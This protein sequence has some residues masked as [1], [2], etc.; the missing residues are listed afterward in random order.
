M[1]APAPPGADGT[2]RFDSAAGRWVLLTTVLGSGMAFLDGTVVTVALPRIGDDLGADF[3]GLSWISNAYLVT[4][5]A[6][7]LVGGSTGDRLGHRRTYLAG[8]VAFAATS[9]LCALA[10][11]VGALVGARLLQGVAAAFLVPGSLALL[12]ASFHPDDRSR[13]IGAWSGLAGVTTAIGPFLGGWLVEVATWRWVFLLNLPLAA[14][15]VVIGRRHLPLDRP[16]RPE[17]PPDVL[18]AAVVTI[19]LAATT[20]GLVEESVPIAGLGVAALVGFV[21]VEARSAHPMLPLSMFRVPAFSGANVTTFAVYGALGA[22]LFL[23][24]LVLQVALGYS[25]L[26]AGAATVPITVVMLA[27]SSRS[28]ALA[29]RIG[30]RLPMTVGPSVI[31]IGLLLMLRIEPGTSYVATVLPALLVFSSGLTLTVAPLTATVLAAVTPDHAG[32]ASGV[33]NAVAR[34]AGLVAVASLPLVAGLD[35][36]TSVAGGALV[37][38]FHRAVVVSA[39]VAALGGVVAWLTV[40]SAPPS[41]GVGVPEG[42]VVDESCFHCG[43][44]GPPPPVGADAAAPGRADAA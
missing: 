6:L 16:V 21:V 17:G 9:L 43:V 8:A 14:A 35:A 22:A 29:Q 2:L 11:G 31:A 37:D 42:Q 39:V 1:A 32:T 5:S 3:G 33:N 24:S 7:I 34:A 12:Q 27:F 36:A 26:E 25:P 41:Q 15:V 38:G 10:P 13:A 23:L 30:A 28:G 44:A 19:G 18:G 20:Y 40:P 4:L